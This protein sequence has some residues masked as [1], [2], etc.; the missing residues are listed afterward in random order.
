M[1]TIQKII[2]FAG[3]L[4]KY[5]IN[6]FK[7]KIM[8]DQRQTMNAFNDAIE[9]QPVLDAAVQAA[10][11]TLKP[12]QDAYDAAVKVQNDNVTLSENLKAQI[13]QVL[14]PATPVVPIPETDIPV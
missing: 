14:N 8:T 2:I 6:L 10:A 13:L 7:T 9:L 3:K 12:F 5:I 11:E 1:K 4:I